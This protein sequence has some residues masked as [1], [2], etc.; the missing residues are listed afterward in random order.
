MRGLHAFV[1]DI[2]KDRAMQQ[3]PDAEVRSAIVRL[4]DALCSYERATGLESVLIIREQGGFVY[5]AMG[6][7]PT[8]PVEISDESL[9]ALLEE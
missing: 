1:G 9:L 7:K 3:H 6:G 2:G 5:R 8:I 4:C